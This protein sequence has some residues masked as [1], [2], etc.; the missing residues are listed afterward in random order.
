MPVN[1][2]SSLFPCLYLYLGLSVDNL[3]LPFRLSVPLSVPPHL[4]V[5]HICVYVRMFPHL[6]FSV[7]LFFLSFLSIH[8]CVDIIHFSIFLLLGLH[9]FFQPNILKIII[10][11][12]EKA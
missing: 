6:C 10:L 4:P 2:L 3:S 12:T 7:K 5:S 11:V 1:S 9:I 8:V